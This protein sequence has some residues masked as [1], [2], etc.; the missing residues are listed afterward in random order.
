[1]KKIF[2][3][4]EL[5]I[6]IAII[7]ILAALLLPALKQARDTA[8]SIVCVGQQK[9][10]IL[11]EI[12]YSNDYNGVIQVVDGSQS[13]NNCFWQLMAFSLGYLNGSMDVVICPSWAPER[14]TDGNSCLQTYGL[15]SGGDSVPSYCNPVGNFSPYAEWYNISRI[16]N[17]SDFLLLADSI[18][19]DLGNSAVHR[20]KQNWRLTICGSVY[21]A[22][23][24]RIHLRH[25]AGRANAA[26]YDG[27]AESCS[28]ERL[29]ESFIKELPSTA[30]IYAVEKNGVTI[31]Q[32]NP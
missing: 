18:Y 20:M 22:R 1:M 8:E 29:K 21:F 24:E 25:T 2:T 30:T 17:P 12:D 28:E 3:L 9:Q 5:L 31:K 19:T 11:A 16:R 15:R 14:Y 26:F 23:P 10:C 27:H 32:I 7:S 6:V 13:Y 4:V